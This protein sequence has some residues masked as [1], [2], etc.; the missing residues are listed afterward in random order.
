VRSARVSIGVHGRLEYP[1]DDA[2]V[3][4]AC[5]E[6]QSQARKANLLVQGRAEAVDNGHRPNA[7]WSTATGTVFAQATFHRAQEDAQDGAL[8]GG[9]TLQK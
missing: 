4:V 3:K 9:V 7:G 8:Y 5:R 6:A 2:A 1:I